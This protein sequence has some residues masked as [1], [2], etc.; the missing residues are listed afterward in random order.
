MSM[1]LKKD[2]QSVNRDIKALAKKVEKMIVA[3]GKLEKPK[4]ARKPKTKAVK[5]K[6]VK[7]VIAKK[8]AAKKVTRVT[9]AD[10][11]MGIIKRYKKGVGTAALMKKT[12]FDQK[13][14]ANII[15]KLK[16]QGK[17]TS[18]KKGLYVKA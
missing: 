12:G 8:S 6:P 11:V 13:K 16:K 18:P 7:K 3:V 4:V 14:V 9:A 15:F 2:L 1:N 10:A 5:A 17:I